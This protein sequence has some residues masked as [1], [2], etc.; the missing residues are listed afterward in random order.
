MSGPARVFSAEVVLASSRVVFRPDPPADNPDAGAS[1]RA[2]GPGQEISIHRPFLDYLVERADGSFDNIVFEG[3][4]EANQFNPD[5]VRAVAI[6]HEVGH[7]TLAEL[8][9]EL[10]FD[11]NGNLIPADFREGLYNTRILNTCFAERYLIAGVSC[12]QNVVSSSIF[13]TRSSLDCSAT[14]RT[15]PGPMTVSWTSNLQ[16]NVA[17]DINTTANTD[18]CVS[19]RTSECPFPN[20]ISSRVAVTL[21]VTDATGHTSSDTRLVDCINPRVPIW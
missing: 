6:L 7:L 21:S 10:G 5:L 8:G 13:D 3:R 11:E 2:V 9:H 19:T 16:P 14:C 12:Y 4:P 18:V 20:G 15:S 1:I 17:T